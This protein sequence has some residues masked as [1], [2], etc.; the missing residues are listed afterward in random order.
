MN[1]NDIITAIN[2]CNQGNVEFNLGT[3][4]AFLYGKKWYP[5]RGLVNHAKRLTGENGDLTTDRALVE[6]SYLMPYVRIADIQFNNQLP[7]EIG[8]ETVIDEMRYLTD[9]MKRLL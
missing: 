4:R 3:N 1:V 7:V 5:L 6:F 8:Q 2:A 9:T